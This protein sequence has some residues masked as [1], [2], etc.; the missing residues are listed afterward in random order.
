MH[1]LVLLLLKKK[2]KKNTHFSLILKYYLTY[3]SIENFASAVRQNARIQKFCFSEAPRLYPSAPDASP[4]F[5]SRRD[6]RVFW[7]FLLF[8]CFWLFSFLF[9]CLVFSWFDVSERDVCPSSSGRVI[10]RVIRGVFF[11]PVSFVL[12]PF[13]L[14]PFVFAPLAFFC[15]FPS[16][17]YVR[18]IAKVDLDKVPSPRPPCH[19][20]TRAVRD[21]TNNILPLSA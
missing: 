14:V 4:P 5:P 13:A 19:F 6:Q 21:Y 1:T 18:R 12:V 8:F 9:S 10:F 11:A 20:L 16:S 3:L 7:L 17:S 2:R 15:V